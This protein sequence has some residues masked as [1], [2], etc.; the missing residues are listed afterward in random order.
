MK[1]SKICIIIIPVCIFIFINIAAAKPVVS[2]GYMQNTSSVSELNYLEYIFPNSFANSIN[3]IFDVVV[4]KPGQLETELKG[5]SKSLKKDYEF[6]ELP[7]FI[8]EIKSDIFIYGN[9]T[10]MPANQIKIILNIYISGYKETFTFTNIGK[11]ETQIAKLVD[12]ISIIILNFMG[13][14]NLYKVRKI[15]PGTRLSILT[16]LEGEEQNSLLIAFMEKGYPVLCFQSNELHN[17]ID[18]SMIQKFSYIRT[19]KNSYDVINDWRKMEFYHGTWTSEKYNKAAKHLKELFLK[20]D[21]NYESTKN[22]YLEKLDSA[23][24]N[25]MEILLIIGFSDNRR[26]SWVRAIDIKEKEMI[27][28]QSN[29]KSDLLSFDP[30]MSNVNKIVEWMVAEPLNPFKKADEPAEKK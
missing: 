12:R 17:S 3:A 26:S 27:W 7:D 19:M 8:K 6:Y 29:I 15:M 23:Y 5:K 14:H 1:I 9:F 16:N 21:F 28:M 11:M 2:F 24:N 4:K 30:V 18:G 22:N 13:E 20:Y 10:P 25:R